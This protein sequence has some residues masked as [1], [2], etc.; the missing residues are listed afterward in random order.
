[1]EN[2]QYFC[3]IKMMTDNQIEMN[4]NEMLEK[5]TIKDKKDSFV[6]T[7]SGG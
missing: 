7:L 6:N 2:I 4:A 5:L 3:G 1:M